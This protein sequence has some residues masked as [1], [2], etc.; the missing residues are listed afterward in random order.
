MI[1]YIESDQE[2]NSTDSEKLVNPFL[3]SSDNEAPPIPE[4]PNEDTIPKAY[5]LG[6]DG[7][8]CKLK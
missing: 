3:P 4:R 6:Y 5:T 7:W 1:W 2:S 8:Y